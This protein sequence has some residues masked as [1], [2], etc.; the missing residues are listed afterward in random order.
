MTFAAARL[1]LWFPLLG[2]VAACSDFWG[3]G[4]DPSRAGPYTGPLGHGGSAVSTGGDSAVSSGGDSAMSA[5]GDASSCSSPLSVL[6]AQASVDCADVRTCAKTSCNGALQQCLGP[7]YERGVVSG[8][9]Q[10]YFDC[11]SGCN[12]NAGCVT[13]CGTSG[14]DACLN[15]VMM[16]QNCMQGACAQALGDCLSANGKPSVLVSNL[17]SNPGALAVDGDF[18]YFTTGQGLAKI[19]KTGGKAQALGGFPNLGGLA[20]GGGFIYVVTESGSVSRSKLDGS[21]PTTI[22]PSMQNGGSGSG[23]IAFD[24]AN[25]FFNVG[26]YVR[27]APLA[28]GMPAQLIDDVWQ[29]GPN[30]AQRLALGISTVFYVGGG[31]NPGAASQVM[32]ISKQAPAVGNDGSPGSHPGTSLAAADG[33]IRG[34]ATDGKLVYFADL[35]SDGLKL[36]LEIRRLDPSTQETG[37]LASVSPMMNG[38]APAALAT[39]G[40]SVFFGSSGGLFSVGVKGGSVTNL[41]DSSQP[42]AI[43]L[44]D[45][46]VYWADQLNN[47]S[48][49][50]MPKPGAP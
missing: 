42:T 46:Y 14:G 17:S 10:S 48:I 15:C 18:V 49:K 36:V 50:R 20:V 39:D 9:C 37:V 27:R 28:G 43:A 25:L 45:G 41:D 19:P 23:A 34:I 1:K 21:Q 3:T 13:S 4:P 32:A 24:D 22:V 33:E 29:Q 30:M 7:S 8:P 12:C 16:V 31:P 26:P 6:L 40:Q 47:S 38:G 11:T 35:G 5:G 44:D 2:A